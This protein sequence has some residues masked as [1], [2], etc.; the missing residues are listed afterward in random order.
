LKLLHKLLASK[1]KRKKLRNN[2]AFFKMRGL[3]KMRA[4]FY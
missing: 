4:S 2:L 1:R 3:Q